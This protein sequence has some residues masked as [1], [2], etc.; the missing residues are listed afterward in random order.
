MVIASMT[1]ISSLTW[2]PH[3]QLCLCVILLLSFMLTWHLLTCGSHVDDMCSV[4]TCGSNPPTLHVGPAAPNLTCGSHLDPHTFLTCGSSGSDPPTLH[5]G[6]HVAHLTCG[7]SLWPSSD[8][9]RGSHV[10]KFSC[11][12]CEIWGAQPSDSSVLSAFVCNAAQIIWFTEI[13]RW[14][15]CVIFFSFGSYNLDDLWCALTS[16]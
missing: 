11:S 14:Q 2:Q 5:V 1:K 9:Y 7:S 6:P 3:H 10:S 12:A 4:L 15:V 16:L 8:Q 13:S